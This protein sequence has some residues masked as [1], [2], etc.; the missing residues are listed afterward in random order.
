MCDKA[1]SEQGVRLYIRKPM[2]REWRQDFAENLR[3]LGV[4]TNAT[5][6]A[7]RGA[8]RT[9][10][11]D[12][13]HRAMLR[14]ESTHI[15]TRAGAVA[16]EVAAGGLKPEP[17]QRVLLNTRRSVVEGWR[18]IADLLERDGNPQLAEAVRYF[19]ETMPPPLTEKERLRVR[20][21]RTFGPTE[22]ETKPGPCELANSGRPWSSGRAKRYTSIL[23][24][25]KISV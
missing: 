17:G 3:G 9:T 19:A 18:A 5:E 12:G 21:M 13:I 8:N 24:Y 22:A 14:G 1:L 11:R 10:K 7:V 16:R 15:R 23:T 20:S 2:L 4:E 6:R 25:V